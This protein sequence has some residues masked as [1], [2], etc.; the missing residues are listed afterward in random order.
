MKTR[1]LIFITAFAAILFSAA[2]ISAQQKEVYF[3]QGNHVIFSSLIS[4]IDS[5]IFYNPFPTLLNPSITMREDGFTREGNYSALSGAVTTLCGR[6]GTTGFQAGN[7]GTATFNTPK[8]LACDADGNIF[9][10]HEG[11]SL[12]ALIDL[13]TQTVRRLCDLGNVPNAQCVDATGKIILVPSNGTAD[14]YWKLDPSNGWSGGTMRNFQHPTS[15]E[16]A[17]GVK[18]FTVMAYKHSFALCTLDNKLYMRGNQDGAVIRFDP[19]TGKGEWALNDTGQELWLVRNPD[20]GPGKPLNVDS[21]LVFD[22]KQP[23]ILYAALAGRHCI[24]YLNIKTGDTG[25]FAGSDGNGG[26]QDGALTAARFRN[27]RQMAVDNEGNLIIA[28]GGN[29]CIRKINLTSKT[30]STIAGSPLLAAG[31]KDGPTNIALFNSPWGVCVAKD[32]AIYV[33]DRENKCIRKIW[34]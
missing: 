1:I 27:P 17:A 31:Y 8:H 3:M 16:I 20:P 30:V 11:G 28:E 6:T 18:D 22:P 13:K 9:L 34:P 15:A 2:P 21:Y 33:A 32:G 26:W 25:I 23:H 12:V 29:N 24:A 10:T 7:F 4:D 14:G 5:I 19:V